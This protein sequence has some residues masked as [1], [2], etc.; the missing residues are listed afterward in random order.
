MWSR[1]VRSTPMAAWLNRLGCPSVFL[2]E[3]T[4]GNAVISSGRVGRLRPTLSYGVRV[5]CCV[6]TTGD[7]RTGWQVQR[8][9]QLA[10]L[11]VKSDGDDLTT[12]RLSSEDRVGGTLR[13]FGRRRRAC[14]SPL[15]SSPPRVSSNADDGLPSPVG[16]GLGSGQPRL[17][18]WW[19]ARAVRLGSSRSGRDFR[20]GPRCVRPASVGR[21]RGGRWCRSDEPTFGPGRGRTAVR[22]LRAGAIRKG[23]TRQGT[24]AGAVRLAAAVILCSGA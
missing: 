22:S 6:H 16:R 9:V 15:M 11:G 23:G 3:M 17:R 14:V 10:S 4:R 1:R 19:P 24:D 5:A 21:P 2:E 13:T 12:T 18:S 20:L 8:G 7:G